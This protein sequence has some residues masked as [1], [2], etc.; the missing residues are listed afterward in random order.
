MLPIVLFLHGFFASG[1][2]IPAQS[3]RESFRGEADV[4]SPDLPLHP[5][6][7]LRFIRQL[8]LDRRPAVIVGNSAGSFLAQQIAVE[9]GIPALLGN[10]YFMMTEFLEPRRGQQKYK[11][12]RSDAD[13]RI[14]PAAGAPVR[15]RH[16]AAAGKGGGPLRH[17]R[18]A[19][20]FRAALSSA[21]HPC[22]PLSRRAYANGGRGR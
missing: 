3:L 4:L 19:G 17:P 16:A 1:S 5:E 10:P 22:A 13:R 9:L 8:C 18:H 2:C 7:S 11:A 20:P 12:P 21:L 15:C 14:R 6:Q